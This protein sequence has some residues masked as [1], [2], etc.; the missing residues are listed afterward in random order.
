M[1]EV[2]VGVEEGVLAGRH[3]PR[4]RDEGVVIGYDSVRPRGATYMIINNHCRQSTRG[5]QHEVIP[6]DRVVSACRQ[7]MELAIEPTFLNYRQLKDLHPTTSSV[8][9]R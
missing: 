2:V 6:L 1:K 4:G 5:V 3:Y 9:V 8:N 7:K